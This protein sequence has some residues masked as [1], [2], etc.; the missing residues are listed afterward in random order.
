[1]A[2]RR[3]EFDIAY[4]LGGENTGTVFILVGAGGIITLIVCAG[5]EPEEHS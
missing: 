1:V 2:V 4:F 3:P 5:A